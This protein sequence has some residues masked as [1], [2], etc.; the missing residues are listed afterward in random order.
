MLYNITEWDW[1]IRYDFI[2]LI[3]WELS[4]DAGIPKKIFYCS[5]ILILPILI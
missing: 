5:S 4:G 2:K 1:I 3:E